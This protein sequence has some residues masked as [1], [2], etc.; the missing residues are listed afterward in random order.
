M[1]DSETLRARIPSGTP[2]RILNLQ[3]AANREQGLSANTGGVVS[4]GGRGRNGAGQP[5][6]GRLLRGARSGER[7]QEGLQEGRASVPPRQEP[8]R[9]R[10]RRG[11]LQARVGSVSGAA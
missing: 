11:A 10:R 2:A 9:P 3:K 4:G 5:K 1:H 8:R 7:R 6:L